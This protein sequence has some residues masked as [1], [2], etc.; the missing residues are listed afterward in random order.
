MFHE[1]QETQSAR[2]NKQISALEM[3]EGGHRQHLVNHIPLVD[4]I[5]DN[6]PGVVRAKVRVGL[7]SEI[8]VQYLHSSNSTG[9]NQN[10]TNRAVRFTPITQLTFIRFFFIL[11]I[12]IFI[13]LGVCVCVC[14]CVCV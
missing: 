2:E 5:M 1:I 9:H 8:W 3:C 10:W 12:F 4:R 7:E 6:H 13:F 14:V 11:F